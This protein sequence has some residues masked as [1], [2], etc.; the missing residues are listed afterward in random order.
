MAIVEKCLG[1]NLP[2]R[3]WFMKRRSKALVLLLVAIAL[4]SWGQQGSITEYPLSPH[5]AAGNLCPGPDGHMWFVLTGTSS[6]GSITSNGTVTAVPVPLAGLPLVP[7]LVGCAFGPDGRLYFS[8]Q[9]NNKIIA[10][11]P[12]SQQFMIISMPA[13]NSG[14]AGLAFGSDGN[15]WI[16]VAGSNVIRR[17]T[18]GGAFLSVIQLASG[19]YPHGP[20]SCPDGN[21]WFAEHNA[22]RVAKVNIFG[23]VTEILLPQSSSQPFSTGC[24]SDGAYFSEEAGRVG[25]V[26]YTTLV[27]TQWKTPTPKSKPTGIAIGQNGKVYFAESGVGK[28]GVMP[29][30]GG[31][32]SEYPVPVPGAF[33]DKVAAG[34]DGRAW[35]S[36]HN[37]AEIGAIQ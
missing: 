14:I 4:S 21:I 27:I 13:P 5:S 37:L 33:P 25:R 29:V 32:I 30:G 9:N 26:D 17:M 22:N 11:S 3:R 10:F 8:D 19:R 15:A 24:G 28:V 6:I 20:S 1:F 36:Q 7:S 34:L 16:M 23:Q 18:P 2:K 31:L 12:G 35:F